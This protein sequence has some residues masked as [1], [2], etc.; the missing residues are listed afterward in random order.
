MPHAPPVQIVRNR[1]SPC[2]VRFRS[3]VTERL[4]PPVPF[5]VCVTCCVTCT[6]TGSAGGG[7]Y[8]RGGG[9]AWRGRGGP[10]GCRAAG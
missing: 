10:Y 1:C 6:T 5:V 2:E 7:A 4:G 9:G 8:C 3:F